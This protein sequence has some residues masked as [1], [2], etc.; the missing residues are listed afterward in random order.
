MGR[1]VSKRMSAMAQYRWV[2]IRF[3][4]F[5]LQLSIRYGRK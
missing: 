2:V 3:R 4:P 5:L 1:Q